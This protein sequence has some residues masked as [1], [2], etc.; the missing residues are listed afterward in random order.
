MP[1]TDPAAGTTDQVRV[2]N[3]IR[4]A[5][6]KSEFVPNQRMIEADLC[7]QFD[8][9]RAAVRAA[10]QDLVSEG[11]VERIQN[12]GAR[13]RSIS[14]KE[15]AEITEVRMVIEGLCAAK[16]AKNATAAEVD[17]LTALGAALTTAASARDIFEY[18]HLG[19][20]LHRRIGEIGAQRSAVAILDRLHGQVAR[21]QSRLLMQPVRLTQSLREHTEI[22]TQICA[23][24]PE[25]AE[26]A[27][28][29]HIESIANALYVICSQGHHLSSGVQ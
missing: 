2:C 22:V 29:Q 3:L 26:A 7:V 1:T 27:M 21:H 20:T 13:V 12:R 5:I 25:A 11:L 15:A 18:A 8:A 23:G 19:E 10:L 14:P 6:L 4:A 16:A 9:S 24:N 28:R 17:E